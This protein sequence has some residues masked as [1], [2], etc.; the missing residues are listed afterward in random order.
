MEPVEP[1]VP[2]HLFGRC[3]A[4]LAPALARIFDRAVGR[5]TPRHTGQRFAEGTMPLRALPQ[6][7][8]GPAT[9][10]DIGQRAEPTQK[11]LRVA[12]AYR[13]ASLRTQR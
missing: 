4:S 6:R 8:V 2:E 10:V 7:F 9:I 13:A 11:F 5:R 12:I 3:A 1:A